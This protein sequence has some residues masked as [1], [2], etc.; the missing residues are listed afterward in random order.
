MGVLGP[1][2]V[3][4]DNGTPVDL[5]TRKQRALLAANFKRP[6]DLKLHRAPA[7]LLPA[8]ATFHH[9]PRAEA[10]GQPGVDD[11]PLLGVH[12]VHERDDAMPPDQW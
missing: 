7:T 11:A 2:V 3:S 1:A 12:V 5:G 10:T 8:R 6:E 9:T 4:L